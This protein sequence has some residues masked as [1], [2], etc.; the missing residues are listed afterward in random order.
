MTDAERPDLDLLADLDA[1][2]LDPQRAHEVRTAA[3]ADPRSAAALAALAATR[4]ELAALPDPPV[5]DGYAERWTAAL[6]A[7]SAE[8]P[9]PG[10]ADSQVA[11]S[12]VAD[13]GPSR[14]RS[15]ARDAPAGHRAPRS[16][17]STRAQLAVA[18]RPS[19][20]RPRPAL[21]AAALLGVLVT[22]GV[23]WPRPD[24]LPVVEPVGLAT[25]GRAALGGTDVG[26]LGDPD[27]RSGCLRA[28]AAPG[29]APDAPLLGG[30]R[31]ELAGRPG[32][33]LVLAAGRP[34]AFRIVVVDPDCGPER[35]EL[36]G[37]SAVE[38]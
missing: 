27:R 35:G 2:L 34:G 19:W 3:L 29:V 24:P 10:V 23:L 31:V 28:V 12:Q 7:E 25:A 16:S 5:P 21:V 11:D 1:G 14:S 13:T 38:P 6:A 20:W 32:V 37:S 9:E 4:A 17:T 33:L 30:R 8:A 18:G 26:D 15:A 36:L 22:V